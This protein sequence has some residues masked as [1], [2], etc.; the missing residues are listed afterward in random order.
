ILDSCKSYATSAPASITLIR[1]VA[2]G[3][4]TIVGMP[5][6]GN[7]GVHWTLT[8]MG[9]ISALLVPVPFV[10]YMYGKVIRWWSKY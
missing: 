5:F 8:I 9:V 3:G 1:Y 7:L 10:F 4:T 2:V 6:Y